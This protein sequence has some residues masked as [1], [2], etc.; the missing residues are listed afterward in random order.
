M[1]AVHLQRLIKENETHLD[2]GLSV[3]EIISD[4]HYCFDGGSESPWMSGVGKHFRHII[5]FYIT[6]LKQYPRVNYDLRQRNHVLET[7]RKVAADTVKVVKKGLALFEGKKWD[8]EISLYERDIPFEKN[9]NLVKSS[10][11]RELRYLVEH[12]VHH[13]AI[14]AMFLK[15]FGY[16]IPYGFGVAQSTIEYEASEKS[17]R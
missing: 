4:D 2:S 10:L 17:S 7:D 12:T 14:I 1:A 13:Y 3:L 5:E 6:F 15:H 8:E 9:N 16:Q 11:S